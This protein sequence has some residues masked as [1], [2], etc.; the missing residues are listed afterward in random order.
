LAVPFSPRRARSE[1]RAI[2]V[3]QLSIAQVWTVIG[4]LSLCGSLVGLLSAEEAAMAM[5]RPIILGLVMVITAV[6]ITWLAVCIVIDNLTSVLAEAPFFVKS[7][8]EVPSHLRAEDGT[9]DQQAADTL[10]AHLRSQIETVALQLN[11]L[12][13]TTVDQTINARLPDITAAAISTVLKQ[14][15]DDARPTIARMVEATDALGLELPARVAE[16]SASALQRASMDQI[17]AIRVA[18]A[19]VVVEQNAI[20]EKLDELLRAIAVG[21]DLQLEAAR[22][23]ATELSELAPALHEWLGEASADAAKERDAD[24][25]RAAELMGSID[26]YAA[27]LLPAIKRLESYD[28]RVLRA[29][30]QESDTLAQLTT[31]VSELS[32]TL[33][34]LRV[35]LEHRPLHITS[36]AEEHTERRGP[37]TQIADAIQGGGGNIPDLTSELRSLLDDLDQERQPS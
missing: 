5:I 7:S 6:G 27:S 18:G 4:A 30:S 32:G 20:T 23:L 17:E 31:S 33:E 34:A 28:E 37:L 35:R 22:Q 1:L 8:F 15:L 12:C 11:R 16:A 29:M 2:Y 21:S 9:N 13:S 36:A 14:C 26:A 24:S 3:R 19:A 25:T 10:A